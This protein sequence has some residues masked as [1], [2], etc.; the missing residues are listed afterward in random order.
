MDRV[1]HLQAKVWRTICANKQLILCFLINMETIAGYKMIG[2]YMQSWLQSFSTDHKYGEHHSTIT[3]EQ[4][5][6]IFQ[7]QGIV[8]CV[9]TICL[10]PFIAKVIDA[11]SPK[12]IIPTFIILRGMLCIGIYLISDPTAWTFWLVNPLLQLVYH[13]TSLAI[14]SFLTSMYPAEVRG[15]MTTVQG[16]CSQ[17]GAAL[18]QILLK[19]AARRDGGAKNAYVAYSALDAFTAI[20][21]IIFS[22]LNLFGIYINLDE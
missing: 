16:I 3:K 6:E 19:W 1:C 20:V 14:I 12:I 2:M 17:A 11:V 8:G 21:V 9:V 15:L 5:T 18:L 13:S 22:C 4:A 10:E 7:V